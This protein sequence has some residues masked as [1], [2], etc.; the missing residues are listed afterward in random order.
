MRGYR[1]IFPAI[2]SGTCEHVHT[3]TLMFRL[4]PDVPEFPSFLA[5]LVLLGFVFALNCG[6]NPYSLVATQGE[7][8]W[9]CG[10]HPHPHSR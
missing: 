9:T 10:I 1:G 7:S 2:T 8:R 6:D 5:F 4:R 3:A